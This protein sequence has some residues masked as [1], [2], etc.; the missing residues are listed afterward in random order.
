MNDTTK[1]GNDRTTRETLM[2][3]NQIQEASQKITDSKVE[4]VRL[5]VTFEMPVE[6]MLE[7]NPEATLADAV[8]ALRESAHENASDEIDAIEVEYVDADGNVL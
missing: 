6:W 4:T 8:E 7:D 3:E 2:S 1:H 5:T